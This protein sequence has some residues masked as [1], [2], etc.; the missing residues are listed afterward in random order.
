MSEPEWTGDKE[1]PGGGGVV[2]KGVQVCGVV[3]AH[4]QRVCVRLSR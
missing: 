2:V 4:V 1:A 3:S